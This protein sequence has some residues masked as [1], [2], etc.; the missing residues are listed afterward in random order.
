MIYEPT[1]FFA[2]NKFVEFSES[3]WIYL[4]FWNDFENLFSEFRENK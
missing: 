3:R 1:V 4:E 2:C